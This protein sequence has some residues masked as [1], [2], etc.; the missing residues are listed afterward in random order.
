MAVNGSI[1]STVTVNDGGT[2]KGNGTIG[3]GNIA[4]G[5]QVAPGNSIGTLNVDGDILFAAGSI[6]EVEV[7][8]AGQSDQIR[9]T[10]VATI[11][12]GT[13]EV[14]AEPGTYR[15]FT[16]YLI[17]EADSG[18]DGNAELRRHQRTCAPYAGRRTRR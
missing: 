16:E 7:N 3:G 5:G 2:L 18:V 1:V 8:A 14:L 10:G 15:P 13:V 11:Q 12:G 17:L 4:A 6:Y 9:A